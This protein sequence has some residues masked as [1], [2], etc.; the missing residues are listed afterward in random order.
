M[1]AAANMSPAAMCDQEYGKKNNSTTNG[2]ARMRSPVRMLA[3]FSNERDGT[4][5]TVFQRMSKAAGRD[6]NG[7]TSQYLPETGS[8]DGMKMI[9]NDLR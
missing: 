7:D 8:V 4:I 1:P 6:R 3:I 9:I 2:M 5:R